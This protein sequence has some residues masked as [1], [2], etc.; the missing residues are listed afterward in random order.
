LVGDVLTI[1]Y[2]QP[3]WAL[4]KPRRTDGRRNTV[5]KKAKKV[6]KKLTTSKS[7]GGVKTLG[8]PYNHNEV[9]LRG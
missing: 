6:T 1:T 4:W 2:N 3:Q 5:A 7:L 8:M 9:L